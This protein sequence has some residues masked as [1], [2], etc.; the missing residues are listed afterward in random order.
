MIEEEKERTGGKC[1]KGR[2]VENMKEK[3]R[4]K[5]GRER[6]RWRKRREKRGEYERGKGKRREAEDNVEE[7]G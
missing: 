2:R 4:K 5:R 3:I 6:G 1:G 7:K